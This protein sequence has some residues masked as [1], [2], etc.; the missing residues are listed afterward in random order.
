MK[1]EFKNNRREFLQKLGIIATASMLPDIA[2]AGGGSKKLTILHTNDTHSRID[3]FPDNDP[4]FA[5]KGG[6]AQRAAIIN[7]VR[8]EEKNVLLLDSGDIYQGTPYFNV[9]NGSLE[10]KLM[11]QLGYDA[12]TMGN[13]DFDI[14]LE[15]FNANLP[16]ARFPFLC[17]NY[18]FSKTILAGKTQPWKVFEKQ[19]LRIGVFG[20]GVKLKDLVPP[21][22]YAETIYGDPVEMAQE[23]VRQ[24]QNERCHLIVCLSHLG[25]Q[26]RNPEFMND[27][28]FAKQTRGIDIILGGHSHHFLDKPDLVPNL[29][30]KNVLIAQ[31]G[32]GGVRLG[33][34]DVF[35][36][37]R[38]R[39]TNRTAF[40][41]EVSAL[42]TI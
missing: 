2:I 17:A 13:H 24:L 27:V 11:S 28:K 38:N 26:F 33:R 3:P 5:G 35:F 9:F 12:A 1:F 41:Q 37:E 4:N 18:D 14:G 10:F 32:H 23:S 7:R 6:I 22:L 15:G 19:G 8:R 42:R 21:K 34:I 20:I 39:V 31:T 36:D 25:Y 30:G 29:D 16:K 40:L